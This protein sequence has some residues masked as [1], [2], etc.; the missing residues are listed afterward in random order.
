MI[1]T[2]RMIL[3]S[4]AW[5]LSL[6][7]KEHNRAWKKFWVQLFYIS[8]D[9]KTRVTSR[10][11]WRR[12]Q[13]REPEYLKKVILHG[14]NPGGEYEMV[15]WNVKH[16]PSSNYF[17]NYQLY[18]DYM[19]FEFSIPKYC[20]GNNIAQFVTSSENPK[21]SY[22]HRDWE[23]NIDE[24]YDNLRAFIKVF[25]AENFMKNDLGIL[26]KIGMLNL[27]RFIIRFKE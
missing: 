20:W 19:I 8:P 3:Y 21:W 26:G 25:F 17:V 24:A 4:G 18:G 7:A 1:D 22:L 10:L 14:D 6:V 27:N 9:S 13:W 15:H 5:D 23:K 2:I 12:M 11:P 16:V